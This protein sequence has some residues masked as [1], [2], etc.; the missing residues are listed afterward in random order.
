MDSDGSWSTRFLQSVFPT[1]NGLFSHQ[2]KKRAR[3]REKFSWE[4]KF[5]T[6]HFEFSWKKIKIFLLMRTPQKS[7]GRKILTEMTL[8]ILVKICHQNEKNLSRS[9]LRPS[10]LS[11]RWLWGISVLQ[12]ALAI[13]GQSL[14]QQPRG[15]SVHTIPFP[16]PWEIHSQSCLFCLRILSLRPHG[17]KERPCGILQCC[18]V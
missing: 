17:Y 4:L 3:E 13:T 11:H 12:G 7:F 18:Y 2:K 9:R 8:L 6:K 16:I 15:E 5:F 1:K 10:K 14:N